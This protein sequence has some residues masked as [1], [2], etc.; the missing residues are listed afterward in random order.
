MYQAER[1]GVRQIGRTP[2][3]TMIPGGIYSLN[4]IYNVFFAKPT[5]LQLK[6]ILG[7]LLSSTCQ[8][9]LVTQTA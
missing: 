6:F 2:I 9:A 5:L 3:A 7:L 1:I 4:T 8:P